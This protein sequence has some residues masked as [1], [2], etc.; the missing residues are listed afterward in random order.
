MRAKKTE[1]EQNRKE[2]LRNGSR[3]VERGVENRGE[4]RKQD[5][6]KVLRNRTLRRE[7]AMKLKGLI[8]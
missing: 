6:E 3:K 7:V 1:Q 4:T 2:L 5:R 8:F